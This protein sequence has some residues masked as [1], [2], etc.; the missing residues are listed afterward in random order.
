MSPKAENVLVNYLES[1]WRICNQNNKQGVPVGKYTNVQ[2][3]LCQ[4]VKG[5]LHSSRLLSKCGF[6]IR[7]IVE[8][9]EEG[10][11]KKQR[12]QAS[13]QETGLCKYGFENICQKSQRKDS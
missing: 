11:R 3:L 12:T 1:C 8:T 4:V 5:A 7:K 13:W 2:T 9:K 6:R 10:K